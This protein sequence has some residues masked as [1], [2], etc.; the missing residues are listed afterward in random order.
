MPSLLGVDVGGTFTDFFL[1]SDDGVA[2]YKRPST[3]DDPTRAVLEGMRD[4]GMRPEEVVHG[5]TV[6]ANAI[7]ERKG[8]RT[9]LITTRGFRDVLLIGRQTRP[10]LYDLEPQHE[11]PLVPDGL[12]L[13]ANERL[14]HRGRVLQPLDP[15]EVA[16]ILDRVQAD[17]VESLAVCFLFSFLNP[18]HER[19]V[20]DA[21]RRRGI[22]VSASHEVLPEHR[23]YERTSTTVANAYVAPVMSRYLSHLEDSLRERGVKRL[24]VM[25]SSGGSI[26]PRAAG[27]L[28]VRT[29]VSG[30]AGGVAGA[31]ALAQRSGY[32]RIITLDMGGTSTD[33]SLC[34]GRIL[35]R[36]ET[37]VG[38]LP[39]RGPTVDV[40]SVGAGGGSIARIDEGGALRVGPQSAGAD[41]GPACYGR[42]SQ[43]T[44][45]DAQV[46]LG[47]ISPQHFLD[48]RMTIRPELSLQALKHITKPFAG[49][50]HRAAAAVLRVANASMESALRIVSVERGHD[51]RDF[52]LVAFG[53]AGP[54]HACDLAASLRIPRVL[55]PP[56]PGVLSALGM[57]SAPIVKD[58]SAAVMLQIEPSAARANV[59]EAFRPPPGARRPTHVATLRKARRTVHPVP[60]GSD[61]EA[62]LGEPLEGRAD[63]SHLA[64]I[65]AQLE[66]RGRDELNAE[67]F[68]LDD[69][70]LQTFLHMR[71]VGQSYELAVPVD[72]LDP[73]VFLPL[74][75]AAHHERYGHSDASRPVEIVTAR[76]K[77]SLPPPRPASVS[78]PLSRGAGEGSEMGT[79]GEGRPKA[80]VRAHRKVWFDDKPLSTPIYARERLAPGFAF[81]GPAI[82]AQ[83]DATTAVPPAWRA[84]VDKMG[85]I[86]LEPA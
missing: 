20:A 63:H 48:G 22:T 74:F 45:T 42:G 62:S 71:Y 47:R 49:D 9:A 54:L 33:V 23:E 28:A 24:R 5:A 29:A 52:T 85:N 51:P 61:S 30:P 46:A 25:S 57:A 75:H 31:F 50:P 70:T 72:S 66:Q 34:P 59:V 35:E 27:R 68:P 73:A 15:V 60:Q 11:P 53:G 1:I 13:E 69:L 16:S 40:L 65:R 12:R 82:V 76:L 84:E 55:I 32:D 37:L 8:A 10:R 19:L 43:L 26:S 36:D 56:H 14:D 38:G 79:S 2:V 44:V 67:G 3:P 80:G 17:G 77:L 7:I 83:M 86:I 6:A 41:P 4:L 64:S 58:L 39:I 78:P 18:D 21:A 81:R